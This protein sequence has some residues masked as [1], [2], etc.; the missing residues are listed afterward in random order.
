LNNQ[1]SLAA[2]FGDESVF[3]VDGADFFGECQIGSDRG[4]EEFKFYETSMKI[5]R[6]E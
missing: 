5:S 6:A 1:Q 4:E 3:K 2:H